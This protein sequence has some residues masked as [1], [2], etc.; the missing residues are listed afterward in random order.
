MIHVAAA[1]AGLTASCCRTLRPLAPA[2][3]RPLR[4]RLLPLCVRFAAAQREAAFVVHQLSTLDPPFAASPLPQWSP[5]PWPAVRVQVRRSGRIITATGA[6]AT[7]TDHCGRHS[8]GTRKPTV[9]CHSRRMV[10]SLAVRCEK[11]RAPEQMSRQRLLSHLNVRK[12]GCAASPAH[13]LSAHLWL[14]PC[15][16]LW[17]WPAS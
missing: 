16:W 3:A 1:P 9:S 15:P 5:A 12:Q 10:D 13:L 17:L 2:V 6:V 7:A 11:C 8:Y 4:I 14:C